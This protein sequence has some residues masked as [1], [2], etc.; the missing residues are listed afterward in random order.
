MEV[1]LR[2]VGKQRGIGFD[3]EG[4]RGRVDETGR[5]QPTSENRI[6]PA[7]IEERTCTIE[8]TENT[9]WKKSKQRL[10]RRGIGDF[11]KNGGAAGTGGGGKV[12]G[13]LV[14]SFVGQNR[15]CE[16]FLGILG[17]AQLR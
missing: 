3:E 17:N 13:A 5:L 15:E 4:K 16:G 11:T 14:E 8:G 1:A 7:K 6:A 9:Q 10:A 12:R 2:D